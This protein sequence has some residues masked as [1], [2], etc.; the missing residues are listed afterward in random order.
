MKIL[1]VTNY[2]Y[3]ETGAAPNRV[4]LMAEQLQFLGAE[5]EVICPLPN[6]PHGTILK[7]Y[8]FKLFKIEKIN[9][10]KLY[11]FF[12]FPSISKAF[13]ARIFSMFSFA[14]SLWLFAFNY[15]SIKNTNLVIVQHS[16]LLV[17]FSA[18]VLFKKLFRKKIILNVSDL[19][20]LSALELGVIK[21]GNFYNLLE[22]IQKFNYNN[23]HSFIGQSKEILSQISSYNNKSKI[24]YRNIPRYIK[25]NIPVKSKSMKIVY[26][27]LLGVAQGVFSIIENINFRN[28]NIELHIYGDGTEKNKIKTYVSENPNCNIFIKDSLPKKELDKIM[29]NFDASLI[30]LRKSIYG[31]VPSK[32][33]DVISHG[34]PVLFCGDG[35][36]EKIILNN[37]LGFCSKSGDFSQL[38][39]N[40]V[41][42]K[43]LNKAD[44]LK[45]SRNCLN[46]SKN[47][48]NFQNQILSLYNFL[49]KQH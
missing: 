17:S 3:P 5:V 21:K 9:N 7:G 19:W 20:P 6:Y 23:A 35:E 33:F 1:I 27:G 44:Y 38:K 29:S 26:A 40:L 16:P 37:K 31:A 32:I 48:Y 45:L 13:S 36:G 46:I 22:F 10:I 4:T 34:L 47:K 18:I 11:R 41:K 49:K 14:F 39:L 12:I 2:Y 25:P 8:K 30:P 28:I 15:K 43:N 42:L 24:L